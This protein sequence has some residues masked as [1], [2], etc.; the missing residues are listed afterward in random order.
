VKDECCTLP[1]VVLV[2][3][4]NMWQFMKYIYV[5]RKLLPCAT[6]DTRAVGLASLTQSICLLVTWFKARLTFRSVEVVLRADAVESVQAGDRYDFTGTL[7]VVPD[8]GALALPGAKAEIGSRHKA[9]ETN[10]EGVRGLKA[11]GVRELHYRMAFLA[12]SVQSTNPR[13]SCDLNICTYCKM[14]LVEHVDI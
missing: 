13:V 8:V 1:H 14:I 5:P 7:I 9:G 3:F 6:W 4:G 2:T 10:T 11:L 12:C